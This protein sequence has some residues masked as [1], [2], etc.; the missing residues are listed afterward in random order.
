MHLNATEYKKIIG[1]LSDTEFEIPISQNSNDIYFPCFLEKRI[2]Q[3][4]AYYSSH[5]KDYTDNILNTLD[6]G[7]NESYTLDNKIQFLATGIMT[8]V[9]CYYR[10]DLREASR[11]FDQSLDHAGFTQTTLVATIP[12][13]S[14]FYRTRL[15]NGRR[16]KRQDLFHNPFENRHLV[17]TSRY[18]IP[19][20][21]ALYLGS[22]VYV[23]WEEFN[24]AP[25]KD[26]YFS[27]FRTTR[28]LRVVKIQRLDDLQAD[29]EA[30][31]FVPS[32]NIVYMLRYLLLFPLTIACS[33]RTKE[34]HG[35]FKPEYII[36][37]LL[38][39]YVTKN[40]DVDGIM[41]PSTKVD[42][43]TIDGVTAYNYVFPVKQVASQGLCSELVNT[44]VLT[45]PT[46]TEIESLIN[47]S[48]RF[49]TTADQFSAIPGA[50]SIVEGVSTPY[51]ATA[52][53]RLEDILNLRASM[54]IEQ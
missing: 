3:Y 29:L 11:V 44:F 40:K 23:C 30:A 19:G 52:F 22:S 37:Q 31:E 4:L 46:S 20:L 13:T 48:G 33:I 5:L 2:N 50:I 26:L 17:A 51:R 18:S 14:R 42:Y 47:Y 36:P 43:T 54:P 53:G 16:M 39:Q 10:G 15:S 12:A 1:L 45:E 8:A 34:I 24:Q 25:I 49:I 9:Q 35:T 21:P 6:F 27:Q 32:V 41:F 38:L 28:P 7:K